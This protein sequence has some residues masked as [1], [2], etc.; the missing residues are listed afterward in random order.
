VS[1][2]TIRR[3]T[4]TVGAEVSGVDVER[5]TGDDGV[6]AAVAEALEANGGLVFRNLPLGPEA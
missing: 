2:L 4:P 6:A 1:V 5:L 3:L